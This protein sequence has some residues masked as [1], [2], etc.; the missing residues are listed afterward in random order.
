VRLL[1]DVFLED[2]GFGRLGIPK[3][4]HLVQK[5]VDDDEVVANR[6]LLERLEVLGEDFD[7]LVEEEEDLGCVGVSFCECEEV[8]VVVSDVEVLE[9][10]R[11]LAGASR[12]GGSQER[13]QAKGGGPYVDAFVGEARGDSRGLFFGLAQQHGELLDGRHGNVTAI[14]PCKERLPLEV[15]EENSGRHGWGWS[16]VCDPRRAAIERGARELEAR[17]GAGGERTVGTRIVIGHRTPDTGR[18]AALSCGAKN[19]VDPAQCC[20]N[21]VARRWYWPSC[22]GFTALPRWISVSTSRISPHRNATC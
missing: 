20:F 5:L 22:S 17:I 12:T 7:N 6:L 3:V 19:N 14:V 10:E 18:N 16:R 11:R 8:E 9:G 4:H 21:C 2:L 13:A 15:E 1:G